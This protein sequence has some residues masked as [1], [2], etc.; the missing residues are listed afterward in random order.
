MYYVPWMKFL[1]ISAL[2]SALADV[3]GGTALAMAV[4]PQWVYGQPTARI[5]ALLLTTT[6]IY[7]GG[8]GL[9]DILHLPKDRALEKER[10]LATREIS[11]GGA[12]G[13]TAFLY[14]AGLG[15]AYLAGCIWPA[16]GLVLLTI[17]YNDLASVARPAMGRAAAGVMTLAL[18]RALHVSLPLWAFA[19]D[20]P[21]HGAYATPLVLMMV[22]S[23]FGYFVLVTL[24]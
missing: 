5:W 14:A 18:C 19:G 8:M 9:N 1:R 3:F 4:L 10:P 21:V 15:G 6:G 22:C 16:L 17:A 13:V 11:L 24:E 23:V 2:P 12:V 20:K 7:L